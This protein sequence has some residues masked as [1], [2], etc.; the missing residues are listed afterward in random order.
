MQIRVASASETPDAT[1]P[2]ESH[3]DAVSLE[4]TEVAYISVS[5]TGRG[6]AMTEREQQRLVKHRFAILQHAE[7]VTGNVA[8]TSRY[9][10]MPGATTT[11]MPSRAHSRRR[12]PRV[13]SHARMATRGS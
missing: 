9:Y 12:G 4:L 13:Q 10:G 7:E 6:G 3:E 2:R 11:R 1:K 8:Q 5:P